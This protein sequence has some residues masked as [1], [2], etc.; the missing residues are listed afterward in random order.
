MRASRL[1]ALA[2]AIA[3]AGGACGG[4]GGG[5]GPSNQDP[6]ADFTSACNLLECTFADASTDDGTIESW[7]WNF[8]DG[9]A[10]VTT[11]DAAHTYAAAGTYD[12]TLT[13]T[14]DEG[15]TASV[16]K[17]VVATTTPANQAPTA[18]FN[19]IC[20]ALECTFTNTSTDADGTLTYS[21]NFD[22]GS[23]ASTEED[24]VHT[25]AVTELTTFDVTLTVTDDDGAT[26]GITK[27][28]AVA[29]PATLTCDGT[30]CSLVL[31]QA[32]TVTVTLVSEEC[33]AAGNIFIIP[34][35]VLDTLFTDGCNSPV[36]GTPEATFQLDNGS[37][38]PQGAEIQAEVISGSD[39]PNRIAPAI[40]VTGSFATG[41]TLKFDDGEDPTG[42]NE[43][44]FND[45]ILTVVATP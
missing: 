40:Q 34:A 8:D 24:P 25:Y 45:L 11:A 39:D 7:S 6:D 17:Q 29:P 15:A 2:A 20:S 41:W 16:T 26:D 19:F 22:D 14:D 36:P 10:L 27:A 13:V 21:W 43:P 42:P 44:D 3:V 4:D 38:F 37:V 9:S 1:L 32:A 30:A 5:G 23:P 18:G 31:D 28:V 12:V 33:N 35:P